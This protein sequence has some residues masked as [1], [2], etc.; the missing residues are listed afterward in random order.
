MNSLLDMIASQLDDRTIRQI[1][2]QLGIENQSAQ[3]AISAAVPMLLGALDRNAHSQGGAESLNA[4]L[5]RDHDG[6]I[7]N[8]L[9]GALSDPNTMQDGSS[10]LNHVFGS[11]RPKVDNGVSQ[12]SGLDPQTTD[13]LMSM[14][15]PVVL[16]AVGQ[17]KQQ[18]GLDAQ[19]LANLLNQERQEAGGKYAGLAKFLD[20]DGDGDPTDDVMNL[21]NSLLKNFFGRR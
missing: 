12:I 18:Q 2:S 17:Q 1:S 16:G 11:A 15:A 13:Q 10:I 6:S 14:L 9:V 3:Q 20:M 4:A 7:L 19:G 21:G 5:D 8:D